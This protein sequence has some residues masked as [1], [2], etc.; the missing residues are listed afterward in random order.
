M[1]N[2]LFLS[3]LRHSFAQVTSQ[4]WPSV[5][6]AKVLSVSGGESTS[7]SI[8]YIKQQRHHSFT[9]SRC[10]PLVVPAISPSTVAPGLSSVDEDGLGNH[11]YRPP[12]SVHSQPAETRGGNQAHS[13]ARRKEI[14]SCFMVGDRESQ[15][16]PICS[17]PLPLG[18][19]P[20]TFANL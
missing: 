12:R 15:P 8:C 1:L 10:T 11:L 7:R 13:L 18:P 17:V 3:R 5:R 9:S 16:V 2:C 6:K 4:M 14:W 19:N 20:W